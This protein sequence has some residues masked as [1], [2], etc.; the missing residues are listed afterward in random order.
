MMMMMIVRGVVQ[1]LGG[2]QENAG[3]VEISM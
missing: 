2:C 1:K 3:G